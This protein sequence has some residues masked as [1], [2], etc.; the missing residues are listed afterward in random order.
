MQSMRFWL[1]KVGLAKKEVKMLTLTGEDF[2]KTK[3]LVKITLKSN[4]ML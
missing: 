1:Q 4:S 3:E 2:M